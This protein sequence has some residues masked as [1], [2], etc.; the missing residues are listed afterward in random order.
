[1]QKKVKNQK[2]EFNANKNK[3]N[4]K[5]GSFNASLGVGIYNRLKEYYKKEDRIK[6]TIRFIIILILLI[7]IAILSSLYYALII[8]CIMVGSASFWINFYTVYLWLDIGKEIFRRDIL[9]WW[10]LMFLINIG[11]FIFSFCLSITEVMMTLFGF[12]NV[13]FIV[14]YI[15]YVLIKKLIKKRF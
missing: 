2:K 4:S 7:I 6:F 13:I 3:F 1:M 11:F 14:L 5:I 8:M 12:I 9:K 10:T 15:L